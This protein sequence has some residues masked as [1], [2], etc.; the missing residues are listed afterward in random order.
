MQIKGVKNKVL[1]D[2]GEKGGSGRWENFK[3]Y[4]W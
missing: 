3:D 4:S 1:K 2:N